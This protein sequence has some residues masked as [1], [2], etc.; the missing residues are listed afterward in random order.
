[1]ATRSK[2]KAKSTVRSQHD[3]HKANSP[4]SKILGNDGEMAERIRAFEWAK[5]SLGSMYEWP[6]SLC[7]AV[8]ITLQSPVPLVMLWGRDGIMIYNDAYSVFA[9]A[10]HPSLLGSKVLDGWPEVADFNRNVLR[11]VLAGKTLSYKD[12]QLTL[13][14]NNVAEK[15]SMDLNYSPIMDEQGRP[16]G[17]LAIVV[18]T[19][20]RVRAEQKQRKAEAALNAEREKL[21]S[22]FRQTPAAIAVVAGSKHIYELANPLYQKVF[23]RSE[24]QLIGKTIHEAFPEVAGQGIYELFEN[25]YATGETFVADE[26]PAKFDRSGTG[27]KETGYFRFVLQPIES[28]N[29]K[30][31]RILIHASEVTE[32]VK[33]RQRIEDQNSVLE[34]MNSGA[35]L[36]DALEFLI[37]SV[38]KQSDQK[39]IGSVLL[40][41]EDG[42]HLRHCAAPSLPEEYNNAIDG[43]PIGKAAGSCGTA[44]YTKQ[45]IIADDIA[46]DPHWKDYKDLAS[47]HNLHACWS[48]PLCAGNKVLGTFALYYRYP[49]RPSEADQKIVELAV[50]TAT[51]II[52]R[53]RAEEQL[54]Y[55]TA[56]LEAHNETTPDGILIVDTKGKI[57]SYNRRFAEMWNIP[58]K[59]LKARDDDAALKFAV[60]QLVNP[61]GFIKRVQYIYE[62]T[63]YVSHEDVYFK[64][65]RIFERF[66]APVKSDSNYRYGWAWHFRDVT[67]ERKDRHDLR[68][69]EQHFRATFDQAAVG[70]AHVSLD[71]RWMRANKKFCDILGYSADE[72]LSEKFQ[73]ITHPDDLEA[74]LAA[75]KAIA[76]G[77]IASYSFE[78][79]YIRKDKRVVWASLTVAPSLGSK[80]KIDHF[81]TVLEDITER[82]QSEESLERQSKVLESMAEGVSVTDQDGY[83][84]F[85]N[86]AEDAMFGYDRG[87]L[88]GQHVTVQN[89][90]PPKKNEKIVADVIKQLK[91]HGTWRGE[92]QNV[93]KNGEIFQTSA[94]ISAININDKQYWICV[95]EDITERKRAEKALRQSEQRFRQLADSMPQIVWTARPDGYLDYYNKQWYE[96]TGNK[97]GYGDQS[98]LPILHPDDAQQC[99]DTWYRCV[100]TGKPYQIEYRFKDRSRPGT[101]RWFL[102]KALPV[103]DDKGKII[104]WFGTCTDIDDVRRILD[105]KQELE[106]MTATLTEQSAELLALN[107]AKDEFITLASHQLRTPATGVKQFVGMLIEGYEGRLTKAQRAMLE[108]AYESNE[109][110]LKIIDDL[111][112]VAHVD[113]GRVRLTK[114]ICDFS[115]LIDDVIREQQSTFNSRRQKVTFLKPPRRI[116]AEVDERLIRMVLENLVDNA[117]KYSPEGKTI[118]VELSRKQ[119]Q[120]QMAVQDRGVGIAKKDLDKL[121]QKFS[122]IDNPLS[123]T[124][125]GTGLGLYWVKKIIDLHGGTITVSSR[126]KRG[127][128]FTI[129]LPTVAAE[130]D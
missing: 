11:K 96:Y 91:L 16:A 48:T 49:V 71:G 79:R 95:Q 127:T 70:I 82:K 42:K 57:L 38:E 93:R 25:V 81:I 19:T 31:E 33:A 14:R 106:E 110:Q 85:T 87:E 67:Q 115:D 51:L 29:Q 128:T 3:K 2:G 109:R 21:R 92:W 13:F 62:H 116:K 118:T 74:S 34:M 63:D 103:R 126:I 27:T 10:R 41:D 26:F 77:K 36:A 22:L 124:V 59:I 17:V 55:R 65:G 105:R 94:R 39:M 47:K 99:V 43:I 46:T 64:D 12:Q 130:N 8:N 75:A 101:Y 76:S 123:T 88:I 72:I 78:K 86:P 84:V 24:Q 80:G 68:E 112:K 37:K 117:S 120:I 108:V 73:N 60:Q 104:K 28:D 114:S 52:E 113:A 35:P 50:R 6:Q 69:S 129:S 15:V 9:G 18:E 23:H 122:R 20:Q 66:G 83:I 4:V 40:L 121:F 89:A 119:N 54:R 90:Y 100:K 7:T 30:V 58:K 98:W 107:D 53:K 111:L 32:Q 125:S 102:G 1:M 44:A 5:T 56:L 97:E 45:P 61:Q